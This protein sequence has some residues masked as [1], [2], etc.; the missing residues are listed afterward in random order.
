M[1]S[2]APPRQMVD[3]MGNPVPLSEVLVFHTKSAG[4]ITSFMF[5]QATHHHQT[6]SVFYRRIYTPP[7]SCMCT[8]TWQ[9]ST[10][11]WARDPKSEAL[12]CAVRFRI[13]MCTP[14][15]A[16]APHLPSCDT[17]TSS[18]STPLAWQKTTSSAAL[19]AGAVTR[20][21]TAAWCA[22]RSAPAPL[23]QGRPSN[24]TRSTM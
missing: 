7:H 15:T 22:A 16:A 1:A 23:L 8:T 11:S 21:S 12:H 2:R 4:T 17:P 14:S 19:S 6:I 3:G 24:T 5:H 13:P 9:A 20:Q 10:F 18:S